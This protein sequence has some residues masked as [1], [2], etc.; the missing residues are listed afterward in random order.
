MSGNKGPSSRDLPE[1]L[2]DDPP[3]FVEKPPVTIV[4]ST[5]I[6]AHDKQIREL[7]LTDPDIGA[8]QG[9]TLS[10]IAQADDSL[11]MQVNL[12][13]LPRAIAAC[14]GIPPSSAA[15]IKLR[16][17]KRIWPAVLDFLDLDDFLP[18]GSG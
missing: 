16:D 18:T 12:A 2:R 13:A 17:F 5:P 8:L 3:G 7:V 10:L 14:A 9:V 6:I 1:S 11:A 4:L 15:T